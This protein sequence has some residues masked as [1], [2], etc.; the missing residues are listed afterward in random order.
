MSS[1]LKIVCRNTEIVVTHK[2][3][4]PYL[5]KTAGPSRNSPDPIETPRTITPGPTAAS[6]PNPLGRGA[7][8]RSAGTQAG[9]PD[10]VSGAAPLFVV[11]RWAEPILNQFPFAR[12]ISQ[13]V[14]TSR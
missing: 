7:S 10:R 11:T 14:P 3:V 9:S 2:S 5:T 6:Q 13:G 4:R 1:V 8:G 12:N